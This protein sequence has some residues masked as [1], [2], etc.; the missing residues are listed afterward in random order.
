MCTLCPVSERLGEQKQIA[1][2]LSAG[3]EAAEEA[4]KE[5]MA[6]ERR[7]D[8]VLVRTLRDLNTR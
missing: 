5:N 7:Q 8:R 3:F 2:F 6:G 1:R 4:A